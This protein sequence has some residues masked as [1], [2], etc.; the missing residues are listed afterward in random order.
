[1][2]LK[3]REFDKV[4]TRKGF[5]ALSKNDHKYFYLQDLEGKQTLIR[6]RRSTHGNQKDIS[7]DILSAMYKQLHFESMAAF[8]NFYDCTMS[9]KE[10][11]NFLK[12]KEKI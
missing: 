12:V 1:M 10:Y 8:K 7:D 5:I 2:S 9:H 4:L 3:I 11:I 6:T